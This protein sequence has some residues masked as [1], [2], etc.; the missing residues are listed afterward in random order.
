[1]AN[2]LRVTTSQVGYDNTS[3]GV[4]AN[5]TPQNKNLGVQNQENLGTITG[6]GTL[7][8]LN[9]KG[10]QSYLGESNFGSF[11]QM[12]QTNPQVT[13][14]F[15]NL[16]FTEFETI[17]KSEMNPEFSEVIEE[18]LNSI[19]QEPEQMEQFMKEQIEGSNQFQG[20][21]FNQIR[22]VLNETESVELRTVV[23]DFMKRYM[24]MLS[25]EHLLKQMNSQLEEI[26]KYMF[27]SDK[28]Q[29]EQMMK[30]LDLQ[31]ELGDTKANEKVLKQDILSFLGNYIKKTHDFGEIRDQISLF[32]ITIARYENG[33]KEQLLKIFQQLKGYRGF[34]EVFG[35]MTEEQLFHHFQKQ[36]EKKLG[37]MK[38]Q[39]LA[40][41]TEGLKGAGGLENRQVFEQ[42][43]NSF[44]M[45][46]SVYMPLLHTMIPIEVF[47]KRIMSEIWVDPDELHSG[48][49]KEERKMRFLIKLNVEQVGNIDIILLYQQGNLSAQ[50]GCP[51]TLQNLDGQIKEGIQSI[52]EKNHI[53][54][55]H[56][57][58]EYGVKEKQLMEVF[59]KLYERKQGVNVRI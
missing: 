54:M 4:R 24:D 45:N 8:S 40:V 12:I 3:G 23:L 35:R 30:F 46:E 31:A 44:L 22:K 1:M 34:Y 39:F 32:S 18:F 52:I 21:F 51:S 33:N 43:M 25:G 26:K 36:K 50:I 56:L 19:Q 20:P 53:K 27:R 2:V 15:S 11:L 48:R 6:E 42:L 14:V 57:K 29:L 5:Q 58:M 28:E 55:Q 13:D 59:P 9:G 17:M 10:E 37:K 49:T 47:G 7:S 41:L 16:L 38:S